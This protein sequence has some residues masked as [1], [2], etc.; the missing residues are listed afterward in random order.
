MINHV[1]LYT[2]SILLTIW[3]IAHLVPTGRIIAGFGPLSD[4]NRRIITMEWVAEGL[5]LCFLGLLVLLL[6][7]FVGVTNPVSIFVY[8][9]SALMLVVLASLSFMTG[10]RTSIVPMKICPIIKTSVAILYVL[11]SAL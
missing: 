8:R 7:I 10:F 11:G 5:T 4:D 3:G 2:G 1:L 9:A 6:T